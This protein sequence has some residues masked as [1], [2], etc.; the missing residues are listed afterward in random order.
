MASRLRSLVRKEFIQ[1]LRDIPIVVLVLYT[2][3]EIV[4]CGWALTMDVR[5]LPTAVLD[6]DNSPASRALVERFRQAESF[7][8]AFYPADEAGLGRL[9]D[10]GQAALGLIIPPDLSRDLAGGRPASVQVLVDGTQSN[11]ALLSLGYVTQ[12]VRRYSSEIE[13]ARLDR[14]AESVALRHR[15]PSVINNIRA[16]Y[17]PGLTYIHFNLVAMVTLA[18]V[19]LGTLL[20]AAAIVRE[21][22][23]G[24]LEQ[25]I[26]TPIRPLELILAKLIPMV[27]LEIVG[28]GLGLALGYF[29]FGVAPHGNAPTVLLLFFALSTLAFLASAGIGVWIATVARN[30][31]QALMLSFFILFPMMFLSGTMTPVTAMPEW[32]QWLSL[33]SPMRHYLTLALSL[34]LKGSD[35]SAV[36]PQVAM[37]AVFTAVML[38][39]G[40]TRFKRSLA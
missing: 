30:L 29:V 12:I 28:L 17:L 6:R 37:L 16:W 36:W 1:T 39:I 25:L 18:V 20:A 32:L 19:M 24:T 35:V 7:D 33:L 38:G 22:E 15:L 2:F 27:V 3:A 21:K 9:L 40:L 23:T 31:M 8:V 34:F 11:S 13:V 10:S 26:V 5:H 14:S 4:L